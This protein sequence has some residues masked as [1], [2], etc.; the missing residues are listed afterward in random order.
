MQWLGWRS[1]ILGRVSEVALIAMREGRALLCG[2]KLCGQCC[3]QSRVGH[4]IFIVDA[5]SQAFL[6][7]T[8]QS[9]TL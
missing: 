7:L 5:A 2:I 9:T 3:M 1:E 6:A 4:L 8:F